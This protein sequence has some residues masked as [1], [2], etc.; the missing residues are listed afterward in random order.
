M[1][2]SLTLEEHL[3]HLRKVFQLLRA[4]ALYAKES[5]CEFL[6]DSIQYLG[7]VISAE[8][9]AMDASKVDAIMRWLAMP[10]V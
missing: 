5:K 2:Y 6:K 9:V 1:V 4:N 3:E 7:H 10:Q 8:G